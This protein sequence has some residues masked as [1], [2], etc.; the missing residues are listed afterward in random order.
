[1]GFKNLYD[2]GE[3][4]VSNNKRNIGL[5]IG[6]WSENYN[7][8][9]YIRLLSPLNR[10]NE[11]YSFY[12]IDEKN[13]SKFKEDLDNDN[14][15]L[16]FIII[17]RDVF[18]GPKFF[19]FN[20]AESLFK[21]C[22][23]NGITV[24][25]DIDDDLLN[26]DKTHRA[27][28]RYKKLGYL[29][30]YVI[31]NSNI[32]T[33]PNSILKNQL[34]GLNNNIHVIPNTV[35]DF[36]DINHDF[37]VKNLNLKNVIKIGYFGSS[38]HERDLD[39]IKDAIN[40]VK[41]Y[42]EDKTIVFDLIGGSNN[43]F[44]WINRINI[45]NNY[46]TYPNFVEW[47]EETVDWDIAVAPLEENNINYSKSN[48]KYLEYSALG[49][50]AIYSDVGPY[51]KI[52]NE[53]EGLVV[54]NDSNIW[55]NSIIRLI[56]DTELYNNIIT[57]SFMDIYSN[58]NI[59][60]AVVIWKSIFDLTFSDGFIPISD[61][62]QEFN[63]VLYV[64]DEK[65]G[66]VKN[67]LT[68]YN[69]ENFNCFYLV[70]SGGIINF[71]SNNV[72]LKSWNIKE[73][74]NWKSFY[75]KII[76]SLK[77]DIMQI[78]VD[79]EN[80]FDLITVSKSSDIPLI[81]ETND[82]DYINS[83]VPYFD[84]IIAPIK[85]KSNEFNLNDLNKINF[86]EMSNLESLYLKLN[87]TNSKDIN[88]LVP[89][90]LTENYEFSNLIKRIKEHD[91]NDSLNFYFIG[92]I[93]HFLNDIG[94]YLGDFT[95]D[96]FEKCI[97]DV[98]PDFIGIFSISSDIFN[99]LRLSQ[100]M[101]IPI[102]IP[103]D[104]YLELF[105][106]DLN[107]INL[108]SNLFSD[109]AFNDII[110]AISINHYALLKELYNSD[111]NFRDEV[112]FINKLQEDLYF[113]LSSKKFL[114]NRSSLTTHKNK[115]STF[116]NLQE[117]LVKS[118]NSPM[119]RGEFIEEDKRIMSLMENITDHL[120]K[121][122]L[123]LDEKPL[124][125]VIMP[126][127]NRVHVIM[128]AINSVL[129][130]YYDNWELIIVDDGSTDGTRELLRTLNDDRIKIFFNE[131]NIGVSPSRNVGLEKVS[132]DYIAYLD[133]DDLWDPRFMSAMIGAFVELPDADFIYSAQLL[134]DTYDSTPFALR[135]GAFNKSL[136]NNN[137]Y[138]GI[139]CFM[140]KKE[141]YDKIGGF[142]ITLNRLVDYDLLL[143]IKNNYNMY[144]VPIL[145]SKVFFNS[146][147]NRISNSNINVI[148][149]C[150]CVQIKNRA[151]N[152]SYDFKLQHNISIIIPNFESLK[153]LQDCINAILSFNLEMVE[154]IIVDN[155]SNDAVKYYLKMF[156]NDSRFKIIFND[157][158]YGFSHAV[159]QG[160]SVSNENS[161]IL[162]LN[163]DAILTP[164]AIECMQEYAYT[165]PD[166][167]MVVPQQVLPGGTNTINTHV[168]YAIPS[169]ECDTNPSDFQK[170]IVNMPIFHDGNV[171]ELNFAPFFCAYIPRHVFDKSNGIDAR[172]GRHYRSDRIFC[173]YLCNV[174]NLKIYHLANAKVYHKLQKATAKLKKDDST[175]DVMFLKNE[176]ED[177]LAK[178]LGYEQPPWK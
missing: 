166:C 101:K 172:L 9:S 64:I 87:R 36:W 72:K 129:N 82:I 118:Y 1:M 153:D 152:N 48:L 89:G 60:N 92:K 177:E 62:N 69:T 105:V 86:I 168:P 78:N 160:I 44:D 32:I 162:L 42:F 11:N 148:N 56:E 31:I 76:H 143:R 161:D 165:L 10:L 167:G 164:G 91:V 38:T 74:S 35:I 29:L 57:N 54:S 52:H 100:N 19:N 80:I 59:E 63:T 83:M 26:I 150:R 110:N 79:V 93:P 18:D 142:D 34:I 149:A 99:I 115:K 71:W 49:I 39:L 107:G 145:V 61:F 117:F 173:D 159:N 127:Y 13:I 112:I 88:I 175:F 178:E 113:D 75:L 21:K 97:S 67:F 58:F 163:N 28:E 132:G 169:I 73:I 133:S 119:F 135:F 55:A 131:K 157:I 84:R 137:N 40:I 141:I 81:L 6:G 85:Y 20:F 50:P 102:L 103:D 144:S 24:L 37:E 51:H 125:S 122:S 155:N 43:D 136:L 47:L 109:E 123:E 138:I 27:Y 147:S 154:I 151:V 96:M 46:L 70:Y 126:V 14:V 94:K 140:Y 53:S 68:K 90:N 139:N 5:I 98:N 134:Y 106:E 25:F 17:Q 30:E 128:N 176:W 114:K 116:T 158:N 146:A 130:Q 111:I 3:I 8:C 174:M 121:N 15:L 170:N 4:N 33:V 16:D 22:N 65:L 2:Y 171:L 66:F 7:T 104:D 77:P 156:E 108:I 12:I 120:M 124:I 95:Q 23:A 45:P 41:D